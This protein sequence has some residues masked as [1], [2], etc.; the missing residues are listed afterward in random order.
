MLFL[1]PLVADK[2]SSPSVQPIKLSGLLNAPALTTAAGDHAGLPSFKASCALLHLS[3]SSC[4]HK[5]EEMHIRLAEPARVMNMTAPSKWQQHRNEAVSCITLR[6]W[7]S[8]ANLRRSSS[9]I[10]TS[11]WRSFFSLIWAAEG[12]VLNEDFEGEVVK[13]L[14]SLSPGCASEGK[15]HSSAHWSELI[16]MQRRPHLPL[17]TFRVTRHIWRVHKRE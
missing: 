15:V 16:G 3:S 10:G 7:S 2:S 6:R 17:P 1:I 11:G 5:I 12:N 8:A 4:I 14:M 9:V 13:G